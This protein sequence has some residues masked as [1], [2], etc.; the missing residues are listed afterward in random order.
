MIK[1]LGLLLFTLN[2]SALAQEKITLDNAK[3]YA[4][5]HNFSIKSLRQKLQ[6]EE[7]QIS[8]F[9]SDYF[10]DLGVSVGGEGQSSSY[11]V[12]RKK[13]AAV[14][15]AYG[16]YNLFNGFRDQAQ[17][18]ISRK[19]YAFVESELKEREFLLGLEVEEIFFKYLYL[20]NNLKI[21]EKALSTG[22]DQQKMVQ[23][24]MG[25]GQASM[26]DLME[27]K[28]QS[29]LLSSEIQSIKQELHAAKLAMV[30]ILGLEIGYELEPVGDLPHYHVVETLQEL[31]GSIKDSSQD[32][33]RGAIDV[34]ISQLEAKKAKSGWLPSIDLEIKGGYLPLGERPESG[35]SSVSGIVLAN[36][37]F[38]SGFKTV[39]SNDVS[40]AQMYAKDHEL[41]NKILT[42]MTTVENLYTK[43]KSIEQ[44]VD[45][46]ESNLESADKYYK[47]VISEYQRGIKNS[48]DV[49]SALEL[50][51]DVQLRK[52]N[53][54]YEFILAKITLEKEI[55]KKTSLEVNHEKHP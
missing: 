42:H 6:A 5:K 52:E 22:Q 10:P 54:K 3:S 37:E 44:R 46:E 29:S 53:F 39:A 33:V 8:V 31:L 48:P 55:N 21:Y 15:Y 43:L 45:T 34:S 50:F 49:K 47:T 27:F 12:A 30:R 7:S 28:L 16:R 18:D 40:V 32:V 38:F 13:S 24:K 51:K 17:V 11:G 4:L 25:V 41:K 14:A 9:K 26:A 23:R 35:G 2:F 20:K 36:W 1:K 19:S